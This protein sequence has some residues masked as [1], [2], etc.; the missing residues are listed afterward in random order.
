MSLPRVQYALLCKYLIEEDT[1]EGHE[2]TFKGVLDEIWVQNPGIIEATLALRLHGVT[3]GK[4]RIDI[5]CTIVRALEV[6]KYTI[7][8]IVFD[9]YGNALIT[10]TLKIPVKDS[11]EYL[12]T[13]LF[14]DKPLT[15][16]NIPVH[17]LHTQ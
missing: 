11:N 13:I 7:D 6:L 17:L 10:Q 2:I 4:H 1:P 15:R 5:N 3:R 12:F 8:D 14:D 9:K 16:L